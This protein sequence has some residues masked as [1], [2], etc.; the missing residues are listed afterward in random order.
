LLAVYDS[1]LIVLGLFIGTTLRFLHFGII[2][3]YVIDPNTPYRI[4]WV[5]ATCIASLHYLDLYDSKVIRRRREMIVGL[6]QA[7]G[8][9]CLILGVLYFILPSHSLGRGIAAL[10]APVILLLLLSWRFYVGASG[11]AVGEPERVLI[12][13]TGSAG[14]SLVRE[15]L[16]RPELNMKILGFLDENGENI[17]R[18]LVNPGVIGAVADV[19]KIADQLKADRVILSLAERRGYTPIRQ[20][21]QLKFAGIGVEDV[22]TVNERITGRIL[23]E[24]LSPSWL[25]LSGGFRHSSLMFATKRALDILVATAALLLTWP[26]L[27]L[28]A[29]AIFIESGRPI[30]FVQERVGRKARTFSLVKFRSMHQDA[31]ASGPRWAANNDERATR[32]GRFIRKC[33]LDELPQL[34]N[35]LRGE[36]SLVGPRPERPYFCRML[37]ESIPLYLLRHSV[38]PGITGWAQVRYQYGAS[39][40][41]AKTKL[42]YDFFY[43]KHLSPLLDLVILL[44]TAKVIL[45]RRGAQ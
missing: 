18:S 8:T 9:T 28:V 1:L 16:S 5:V 31:E 25:I 14:V 36:M 33:R 15:V 4:A 41:D 38:R 2:K 21:L 24:H 34:W 32:V 3:S 17:G 40:E 44:E 11:V 20:L 35:V 39:V 12:L 6:F 23:L 10:S 43:I 27:F 45:R 19:E 29:V 13:G 42:E 26:L 22:Y 30:F 37:E 7:L